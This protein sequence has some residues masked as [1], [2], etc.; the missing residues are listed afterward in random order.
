M[1]PLPPEQTLSTPVP[2]LGNL[3]QQLAYEMQVESQQRRQACEICTNYY[4]NR[5]TP[6][7][8]RELSNLQKIS[9]QCQRCADLCN[10]Y[11]SR[12]GQLNSPACTP[13]YAAAQNSAKQART[14]DARMRA[15]AIQAG[16]NLGYLLPSVPK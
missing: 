8:P 1:E 15:Q 9:A 6:F 16:Q 10:A 12:Q 3:R 11:Y 2:T 5:Y 14:L 4:R 13:Y 7:E